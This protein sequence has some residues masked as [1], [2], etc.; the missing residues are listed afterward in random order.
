MRAE[1]SP[2][3]CRQWQTSWDAMAREERAGWGGTYRP[4]GRV[5]AARA[6]TDPGTVISRAV[7]IVVM[8][9]SQPR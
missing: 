7:S 5:V 2:K 9:S 6:A 8:A 1:A 3:G 4:D